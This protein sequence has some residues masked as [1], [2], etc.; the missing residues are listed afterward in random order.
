MIDSTQ[1]QQ[2][3]VEKID[4]WLKMLG[5]S[6]KGIASQELNAIIGQTEKYSKDLSKE[7]NDKDSLQEQLEVISEIRNS[8]MEMEFRI[9]EVQEQYRVLNMYE[10][11]IEEEVQKEVDSLMLNWEELIE[12]ADKQD[13]HVK[14][15]KKN[16][17]EVT[18]TDVEQFKELINKEYESYVKRGPGTNS[19][20]LEEGMALLN[21]SKA[22]IIEFN[23]TRIANVQAER[24]F[25]LEISKYPNL[26]EMEEANKKYD[27]IYSIFDEFSKKIQEFGT[28]T[29]L[30]VDAKLLTETADKFFKD[31]NRLSNRKPYLETMYPFIKLKER[32]GT[33]KESLPL[34]EQLRHPA[35]QERHWMRIIE[36]TGKESLEI[37]LKTLSLSRV[38]ELELGKYEEKV[39]EICVEAKEE[40]KNEEEMGKIEQEWKN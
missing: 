38:F 7:V 28:T 13:N 37:N 5:D 10:Y 4:E 3:A 22:K 15:F 12:F 39:T 21:E 20:D 27:E 36:E 34:I 24:L 31:I 32:V 23:K 17:S 6:L 8:S 26:V 29:F 1:I 35:I 25:N 14:G 9:I 30:K 11:Q 40:L 19:V 16:F 33:F 2:K 18:K